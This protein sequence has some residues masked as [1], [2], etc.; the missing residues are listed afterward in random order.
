M[1]K[2]C[3][4]CFAFLFWKKIK[5]KLHCNRCNHCNLCKPSKQ[6]ALYLRQVAP[7]GTRW[8]QPRG[9]GCRATMYRLDVGRLA[10]KI[11]K[12]PR[13]RESCPRIEIKRKKIGMASPGEN[14]ARSARLSRQAFHVPGGRSIALTRKTP[15][16]VHLSWTRQISGRLVETISI[17]QGKIQVSSGRSSRFGKENLNLV[18]L[19]ISLRDPSHFGKGN[20]DLAVPSVAFWQVKYRSR[21]AIHRISASEI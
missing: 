19:M 8:Y 7:C 6:G 14:L 11:L 3:F 16:S 4:D 17:R 12:N 13:I 10:S 20:I 9:Q 18:E 5:Q 1:Q 15:I 2:G 21:C